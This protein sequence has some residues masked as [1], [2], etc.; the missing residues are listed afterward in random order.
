MNLTNLTENPKLY[1]ILHWL[2]SKGEEPV[3]NLLQS[4][5]KLRGG[6]RLLDVGCG[7]GSFARLFPNSYTGIDPSEK[8]IAF[9]RTHHRNA[10][11]QAM[12]A[13]RMTFPDGSF[14][15]VICIQVSH[16]LSDN[17]LATAVK[18]MKRVCAHGGSVYLIDAVWP[19]K[20]NVI[21]NFLFFIDLGKHQRSFERLRRILAAE[22]FE[23]LSKKLERTFPRHYSAFVFRKDIAHEL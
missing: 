16:H 4:E 17:D 9:A 14:T 5:I 8:Y 6:E 10:D 13:L 11:F 3:F 18:E 21:G 20:S 1:A 12:D 15:H 19:R 23:V 7:T 2:F 22:G